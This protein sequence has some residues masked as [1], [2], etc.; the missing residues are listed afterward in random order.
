RRSASLL[1][2]RRRE[3]VY[4]RLRTAV[5]GVIYSVTLFPVASFSLI[6][7]DYPSVCIIASFFAL[8]IEK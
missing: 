5:S 1:F 6:F 3:A 7:T 8:I 4:R 2:A